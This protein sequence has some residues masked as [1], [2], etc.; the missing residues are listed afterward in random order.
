MLEHRG[1]ILL[2]HIQSHPLL[3]V[4]KMSIIK[5]SYYS[6]AALIFFLCSVCSYY[7]GAAL[8]QYVCVHTIVCTLY[9]VVNITIVMMNHCT[10]AVNQL[11][12]FLHN[13]S[14]AEACH[15][16][17]RLLMHSKEKNLHT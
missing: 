14:W 3:A 6:R 12:Y 1:I 10:C 16:F 11:P 2:F 13:V 5:C 7:S 17:I 15:V 8:I 9:S 4:T